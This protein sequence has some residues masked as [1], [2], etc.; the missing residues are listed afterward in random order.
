MKKLCFRAEF[1]FLEI[2]ILCGFS[3]I[4]YVNQQ[5]FIYSK[6]IY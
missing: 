2:K 3:E 5:I 4:A 1:I 6:D